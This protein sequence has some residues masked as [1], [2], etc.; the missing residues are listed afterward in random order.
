MGRSR[1]F[2][3]EIC[4]QNVVDLFWSQGYEATSMDDIVTATGVNRSSLYAAFGGKKDL[5]LAALD[6]YGADLPQRLFGPIEQV[7]CVRDALKA[8]FERKVRMARE[9]QMPGCMITNTITELGNRDP[10][11][12]HAVQVH[13]AQTENAIDSLLRRGHATGEIG[14]ETDI[15]A[16]ARH[17][18][19]T[20]QGF[21]VLAKVTVDDRMLRQIADQAIAVV[22]D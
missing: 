9:A 19:A 1:A 7:S 3:L 22:L 2:D 4:L 16:H 11:I 14:A 18:L 12:R 17:L 21:Q 8:W 6:Q 5:F 10:D 20:M 15:R 13:L